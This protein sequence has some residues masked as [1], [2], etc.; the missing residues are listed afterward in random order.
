MIRF[1]WN[2]R[3]LLLRALSPR[4]RRLDRSVSLDDFFVFAGRPEHREWRLVSF[5]DPRLSQTPSLSSRSAQKPDQTTATAGVFVFL[6]CFVFLFRPVRIL[7]RS[8][9]IT[10]YR[11]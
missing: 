4:F 7:T 10:Q 1:L 8:V 2:Y 9:I 3:C 11:I 6:F 5:I